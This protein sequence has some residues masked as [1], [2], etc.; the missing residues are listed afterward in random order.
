MNFPFP[1]SCNLLYMCAVLALQRK[2]PQHNWAFALRGHGLDYGSRFGM[3][4]RRYS[5]G[6]RVS[7]E[8]YAIQDRI[9]AGLTP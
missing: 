7:E 1:P 6:F 4:A 2:D 5:R 8:Y 9:A 3:I